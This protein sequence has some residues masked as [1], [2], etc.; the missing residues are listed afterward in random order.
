MLCHLKLYIKNK[1]SKSNSLRLISHIDNFVLYLVIIFKKKINDSFI[2]ETLFYLY[3]KR[4]NSKYN[5]GE[6][7]YVTDGE[8]E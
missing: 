4:A 6:I 2:N 3:W 8:P 5:T 7:I 1:S